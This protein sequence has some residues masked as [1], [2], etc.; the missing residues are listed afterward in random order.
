[1]CVRVFVC[2]CVCVCVYA[3]AHA[4]GCST[5]TCACVRACGSSFDIRVSDREPLSPPCQ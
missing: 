5:D 2:V 3:R 1:M 4:C